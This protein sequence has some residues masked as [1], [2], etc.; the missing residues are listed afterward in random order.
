MCAPA[1]W[2]ARPTAISSRRRPHGR[3]NCLPSSAYGELRLFPW[4]ENF[5]LSSAYGELRLFPKTENFLLTPVFPARAG[6]GHV[7]LRMQCQTEQQHGQRQCRV[8]ADDRDTQD[9][10]SAQILSTLPVVEPDKC[11]AVPL[12]SGRPG[13]EEMKRGDC[14]RGRRERVGVVLTA[15]RCSPRRSA[16]PPRCG[17]AA[18]PP[19]A[20]HD[21][22]LVVERPPPP[23]T[24]DSASGR[25]SLPPTGA[26]VVG[27]GRYHPRWPITQ[28]NDRKIDLPDT[29]ATESEVMHMHCHDTCDVASPGQGKEPVV[30]QST[31]RPRECRQLSTR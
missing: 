25:Q 24:N 4:T 15:P 10:A 23:R 6:R 29:R 9:V 5:L 20:R 30:V 21:C 16:W 8:V 13:P 31:H 28:P 12:S 22:R 11:R 1:G 17:Q 14:W 3:E 7:R 27:R 26:D 18:D 2:M 19:A